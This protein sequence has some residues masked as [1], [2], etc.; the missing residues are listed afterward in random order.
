MNI[1]LNTAT[2][3]DHLLNTNRQ[4]DVD[5]EHTLYC[6]E[7]RVRQPSEMKTTFRISASKPADHLFFHRAD[8]AD[9]RHADG[10]EHRA[11]LRGDLR[12]HAG[13]HSQ[14]DAR[15][16]HAA[17]HRQVSGRWGDNVTVQKS[18][19]SVKSRETRGD[20]VGTITDHW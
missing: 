16:G 17:H 14:D 10:S 13:V 19:V 8:H 2:S 4:M 7:F 20:A 11:P 6:D 9:G 18:W 3:H 1:S 5:N 12:R 15:P